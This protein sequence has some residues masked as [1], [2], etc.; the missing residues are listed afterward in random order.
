MKPEITVFH[1]GSYQLA[2]S[3]VWDEK[4]GTL[5]FANILGCE[6]HAV[7]WES[8]VHESWKF[9]KTVG[10][11]GLCKDG[12]LVV[13]LHDEVILFN[14]ET[15][16]RTVLCR[17]E[18]DDPRTRLNDGKVGPDGAFWVGTM[19]DS[20]PRQDIGALYRVAPDG[21]VTT[22]QTGVR[23]SNGLGWTQDGKTMFH[24]DSTDAW[25]VKYDFDPATGAA[26]NRRVYLQL[27]NT[28]GRPDGACVD[29][30]GNYWSAGVSAGNVNCFSPEGELMTSYEMPVPRPTMPCF[31]GPDMDTLVVTSLRDGL[32]EEQ[33]EEAPLSGDIL[34]FKPG[35]KG[36]APFRFG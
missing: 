19:C 24:S 8:G 2:E 20:S 26:T 7:A 21:T 31:A 36:F 17:I 11:F 13:A 27:D 30:D 16:E 15:E 32:S 3:A 23:V 6:I 25:V 12:R 4:S 18:A 14:P 5:Y 1:R 34:A 35:F 29:A 28:L 10:S 33:L 9:E 22:I